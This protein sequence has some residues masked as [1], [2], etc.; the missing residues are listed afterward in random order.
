MGICFLAMIS[1]QIAPDQTHHFWQ[2]VN[3]LN[4]SQAAFSSVLSTVC[5]V[6]FT[7]EEIRVFPPALRLN[8]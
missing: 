1:E 4:N 6:L 8:I 2:T 7:V 5:N 3:I